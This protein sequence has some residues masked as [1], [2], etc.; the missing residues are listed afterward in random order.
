MGSAGLLVCIVVGWYVTNTMS[1]VYAK[2]ALG[3]STLID[4]EGGSALA[5]LAISLVQLSLSGLGAYALAKSG[6]IG[7][8]DAETRATAWSALL[9]DSPWRRLML[10]IGCCNAIGTLGTNLGYVQGSVSL[11]QLI[12]AME[13]VATV[14]AD[15]FIMG[16]R[17]NRLTLAGVAV[18]IL[19][20]C[21]AVFKDAR[22]NTLS[23]TAA[24]LSNVVLPLRNILTKT[25]QNDASL[26]SSGP[27][28]SGL[29]LFGLVSTVGAVIVAC[30]MATTVLVIAI[31]LALT[32]ADDGST[33]DFGGTLKR[34]L[35]VDELSFMAALNYGAYNSFSFAA[36]QRLDAVSHAILNVFKRAFNIVS[37]TILFGEPITVEFCFGLTIAIGGLFMYAVGKRQPKDRGLFSPRVL[38]ERV[39]M[40]QSLVQALTMLVMT[41]AIVS[42]LSPSRSSHHGKRPLMAGDVSQGERPPM[43][44]DVSQCVLLFGALKNGN[45]GDVTQSLSVTN[46][47]HALD[48]QM[49]VWTS[50]PV[51]KKDNTTRVGELLTDE[52]FYAGD[53][54]CDS[55]SAKLVNHFGAFVIGGGG[56]FTARH[57]PLDCE[58]FVRNLRPDLPIAFFGV[59]SES[60]WAVKLAQPLFNRS[61][62]VGV[63]DKS[64]MQ[65][66]E[67]Q[68]SDV[69]EGKRFIF[70]DPILADG[71]LTD[72]SG[73][74]C[75]GRWKPE[76]PLCIVLPAHNT[77]RVDKRH[78]WISS[79]AKPDD[80]IINVFPKYKQYLQPYYVAEVHDV[81]DPEAFNELICGCR[82]VI[83]SRL[84][85]VIYGLHSGIPTV[86]MWHEKTGKLY[87]ILNDV[88][89]IHDTFLL[90]TDSLTRADVDRHV[91]WVIDAYNDHG[92]RQNIFDRMD[93]FHA[94]NTAVLEKF[95]DELFPW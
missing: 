30:T 25:M 2:Q 22:F 19:G 21:I 15:R 82:T 48:P 88:M 3:N 78:D 13:P 64:S 39:K 49:C 92:R 41:T 67:S 80:V 8:V 91:D 76:N 83:S 20:T 59:G 38:A 6:L 9:R 42:A 36:L 90:S 85:G 56:L 57:K 55:A 84:H 26:K 73:D 65:V 43:A 58:A 87:S 54:A 66:M 63:R 60:E 72:H 1:S 70:R 45:L 16:G 71:T 89:D 93:G 18:V 28:A 35:Q 37:S 94:E 50:S 61:A 10:L 24:L 32:T 51:Y 74:R 5:V 7:Q 17:S 31:R 75:W 29:V 40:L 47:L 81:I 27:N 53:L 4:G 46:F 52:S 14:A 44:G 68:A 12:K 95:R 77:K 11:V 62:F 33:G 23:I 86:P 69:T 79:W 34:L